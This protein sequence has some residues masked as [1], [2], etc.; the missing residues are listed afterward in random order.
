MLARVYSS[1]RVCIKI[2]RDYYSYYCS[3]YGIGLLRKKK[4]KIKKKRLTFQYE[5]NIVDEFPDSV[6]ITVDD[7]FLEN[8][9]KKKKFHFTILNIQF[10]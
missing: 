7:F 5:R 10:K 3:G 4:K 2:F 1:I 6:N 8:K 9:Q